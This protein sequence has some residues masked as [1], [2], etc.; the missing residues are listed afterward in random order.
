[1]NLDVQWF[2]YSAVQQG[3]LSREE[4]NALVDALGEDTDLI[5]M[6]QT[7]LDNELCTDVDALQT[8]IDDATACAESGE[9]PPDDL[10][11][12]PSEVG[13]IDRQDAVYD[14]TPESDDRASPAAPGVAGH[15]VP[16]LSNVSA[17]PRAALQG[18]MKNLLAAAREAG[19]SDMHLSAGVAPFIRLHGNIVSLTQARLPAASALAL[20][21][22]VIPDGDAD[23]LMEDLDLNF[24][25]ELQDRTRYRVNVVIHKDGAKGTY[26]IIPDR[27]LSLE[28]LGFSNHDVMEKLLD[29]HNGL[30][31]VTGAAGSGK[32]TTLAAMVECLNNKRQSHIITVEDPIEFVFESKKC[33]IT[34]REVGTHTYSY[35][36][37]LKGALREDPD[38]IIIGEL[39]DLETI[40][41][42]I[43][44]AETGHLVIGTLHTRDAAGTLDRLLG[45]FPPSQQPQ[46]R[47][48]TSQS[49]RGVVCQQLLARADGTGRAVATE[50][51]INNAAVS[52][53]IRE[54]RTHHLAGVMQTGVGIGMRAMDRSVFELY[55]NKTISK[56]L[57]LA[58]LRST[59]LISRIK[60]GTPAAGLG[61]PPL[62]PPSDPKKKSGGWFR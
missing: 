25:L 11:D 43:T 39:H 17:L 37:S 20:N 55:Q 46:I 4:I 61:A 7:A 14:L 22:A 42:A 36:S 34:Q 12:E 59:E 62:G 50:V 19:G 13:G 32:T 16:D 2:C 29:H 9:P 6:A 58:H 54:G 18:A 3:L 57:A 45:V 56:E 8:V 35:A 44:A 48:M 40:E 49:L 33:F 15:G 28:E 27:I 53:V 23:T 26:H 47:A 41:M 60:S 52:K 10:D 31:L 24:A 38:V 1:V 30:I 51:L 5:T 21:T